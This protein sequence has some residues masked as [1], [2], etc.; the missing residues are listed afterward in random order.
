MQ[1]V[2]DDG[3]PQVPD[4]PPRPAPRTSANAVRSGPPGSTTARCAGVG[5]SAGPEPPP[6]RGGR[7]GSSTRGSA[8]A[9]SQRRHQHRADRAGRVLDLQPP[10]LPGH[11]PVPRRADR[12]VHPRPGSRARAAN[13]RTTRSAAG[14]RPARV[15]DGQRG[16]GPAGEPA[17]R[18]QPPCRP[19]AGRPAPARRPRTAPPAGPPRPATPAAAA[20]A[21]PRAP[22]PR[23]ARSTR[24][25]PRR[26][27]TSTARR[28]V[29][30]QLADGVAEQRPAVALADPVPQRHP[31]AQQPVRDLHAAIVA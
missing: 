10:A 21:A 31:R 9:P 7:C 4:R 28:A 11:R 23:A 15:A 22:R 18:P 6:L 1:V 26:V 30:G 14:D 8:G 17:R 24:T 27:R 2:L 29:G 12:R 20:P 5:G 3:R 13:A 16:V 25:G 19:A